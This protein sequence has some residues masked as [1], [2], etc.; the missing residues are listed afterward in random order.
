MATETDGKE[1]KAVGCQ[2]KGT[3]STHSLQKQDT[4]VSF[5]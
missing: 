5:I 3:L 4:Y 2:E 1:E